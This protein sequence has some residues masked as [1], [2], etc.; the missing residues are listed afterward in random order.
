[1]RFF[2]YR[3][4]LVVPHHQG[5]A[6]LYPGTRID[7]VKRKLR[8]LEFSRRFELTMSPISAT[9]SLLVADLEFSTAAH[10]ENQ[11]EQDQHDH[12]NFEQ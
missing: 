7:R 12:G 11:F 8:K 4:S 10:A 2:K 5:W 9:F 6:D 1:M 3:S